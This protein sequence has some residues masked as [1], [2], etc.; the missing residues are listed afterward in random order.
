MPCYKHFKLI[1]KNIKEG[2]VTAPN[3]QK[4]ATTQRNAEVDRVLHALTSKQGHIYA[5][6]ESATVSDYLEYVVCTICRMVGEKMKVDEVMLLPSLYK[7]FVNEVHANLAL[8]TSVNM[9][10]SDVPT[11]RWLLSRLHN[12]MH[13]ENML[14]VQCRHRR[15]GT[16]VYHKSC[17]LVNALSTAQGKSERKGT[18]ACTNIGKQQEQVQ[19]QDSRPTL[20]EQVQ[21]VALFMNSK[22]HE[23]ARVLKTSFDQNPESVASLNLASALGDID[24]NLLTFLSMMM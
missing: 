24:P 9:S 13:F 10:D 3:I 19:Q 7:D 8:F 17:D 23:R 15:Y 11:S 16:L 14:E 5:N 20:T 21:T 2:N 4:V 6:K 22:L 18:C 12:I 1:D